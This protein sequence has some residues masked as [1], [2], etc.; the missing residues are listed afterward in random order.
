MDKFSDVASNLTSPARDGAAVTPN[1]TT[2]LTYVTRALYVGQAGHVGV[3][4]AGGGAVV[5]S[6]VQAGSLLP[7]RAAGVN[8][9]G[10]TAGSIIALW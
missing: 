3:R 10:T 4:L 1:D 2:D 5:F 8:A 6:N 9:T 7:V